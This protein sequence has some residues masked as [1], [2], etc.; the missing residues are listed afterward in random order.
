[1]GTRISE[2][3]LYRFVEGSLG[4]TA[5]R[6]IDREVEADA[7]LRKRVAQLRREHETI[8]AVRD[9]TRIRLPSTD[10]TRVLSRLLGEL[11]TKLDQGNEPE[12]RDAK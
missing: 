12:D 3:E 1:M 5:R 8:M 10:E 6:R 9:A 2:A 7:D 11:T 4:E